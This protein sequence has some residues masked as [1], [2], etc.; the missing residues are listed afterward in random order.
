MEDGYFRR[1]KISFWSSLFLGKMKEIYW[2]LINSFDSQL[3]FVVLVDFRIG[4]LLLRP[5]DEE[6]L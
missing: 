1:S 4:F 2:V 5:G 3:N 6:D